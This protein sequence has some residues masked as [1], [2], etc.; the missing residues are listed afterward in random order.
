MAVISAL[1]PMGP[2]CE[3]RCTCNMGETK[4]T[5]LFPGKVELS[6]HRICLAVEVVPMHCQLTKEF[7]DLIRASRYL[8]AL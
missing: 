2:I 3:T 4:Q 5:L 6:A 7:K 1:S 8:K